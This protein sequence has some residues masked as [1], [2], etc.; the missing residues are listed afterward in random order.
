MPHRIRVTGADNI[1]RETTTISAS[2]GEA[3]TGRIPELNGDGLI[4]PT[5]LPASWG[6][7]DLEAQREGRGIYRAYFDLS[8]Y[9]TLEAD[10]SAY[11]DY[12]PPPRPCACY[13]RVQ[14]PIVSDPAPTLITIGNVYS[15]DDPENAEFTVELD[16]GMSVC[17]HL[18]YDGEKFYVLGHNLRPRA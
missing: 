18:F 13:L 12:N 4:D 9:S 11:F 7:T 10:N 14:R 5:M 1:C 17:F 6:Y 3:D 8:G 15:N 16:S 2:T